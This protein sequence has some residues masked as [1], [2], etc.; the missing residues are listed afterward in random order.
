MRY[1]IH[2]S[3]ST[4]LS[5]R[6]LTV[7][8]DLPSGGSEQARRVNGLL[9]SHLSLEGHATRFS[10]YAKFRP[11]S[12]YLLLILLAVDLLTFSASEISLSSRPSSVKAV[13]VHESD[14]LQKTCLD[15]DNGSVH[16]DLLLLG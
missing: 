13:S 1:R 5:A 2:T 7:H 8:L 16:L 9:F 11:P 15:E 4:S 14:F 12:Q 3:I 10:C 6:S